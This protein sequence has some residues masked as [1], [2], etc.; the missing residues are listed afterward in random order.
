M[1]I[2]LVI[3]S[4][5]LLSLVLTK[6]TTDTSDPKFVKKYSVSNIK[7]GDGKTFP[8]L[9]N[10]IYVHYKSFSLDNPPVIYENSRTIYHSS[11]TQIQYRRKPFNFYIPNC[12]EDILYHMSLGEIISVICQ[13]PHSDNKYLRGPYDPLKEIGFEIELV[14]VLGQTRIQRDDL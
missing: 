5:A 7:K 12:W 8:V 2:F 4:I 1:K 10:K 9:S 6:V 13:P 3:I 14:Q 11:P